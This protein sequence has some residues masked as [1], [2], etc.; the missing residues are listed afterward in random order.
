MEKKLKMN[1]KTVYLSEKTHLL[2]SQLKLELNQSTLSSTVRYLIKHY[3][4]ELPEQKAR[5]DN[6]DEVF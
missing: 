4:E 6:L 2:L 5:R 3:R 1:K